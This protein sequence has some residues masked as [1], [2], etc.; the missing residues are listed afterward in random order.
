ML[1]V[2][3]AHEI[4]IQDSE[5]P[6]ERR[7]S[8][9][10]RTSI[11]GTWTSKLGFVLAT[12]GAA[13]GLGNIWMFPYM[14]GENGGGAFVIIFLICVALIGIPALLAEMVI[15]RR[16]K[17][18]PADSMQHVAIESGHSGNWKWAGW[19]AML[20]LV[21]VLSF[22]SVVSG[23]SLAYLMRA[24]GGVFNHASPATIQS[25]WTHFQADPW[26]MLLWHTVFMV[27]TMWIIARGVQAGIEKASVIMMP[28]LFV[29]LLLLVAYG[30]S[31]S[32]FDA[33]VS[34]L[35]HPDFS[36]VTAM[37][38]IAALGQALFSMAVGAGCMLI[39][40]AYVGKKTKLANAI[41]IISL[42]NVLVAILAG[43]AIF[44]IVFT[45]HLQAASGPAL[46]YM[47]LPIAF[48]HMVGG[49]LFE[50]LFFVLL[51]F[52]ALTSSV[53]Q[54]EPL[55]A[56]LMEKLKIKR[57]GAAFMVGFV[58]WVIG[59]GSLLSFNSWQHVK[60]FGHWTI[61]DLSTN[62]PIKIILP[63]GALSFVIFAG[64]VMKRT[65]IRDEASLTEGWVFNVWRFL[66]RYTVPIAIVVI[67]IASV[68]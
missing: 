34:F 12:T 37:T 43:L 42:L 60:L 67:M 62:I 45:H 48:S 64:W 58:A 40:G 29:I 55:V 46:M 68:I 36:K 3:L 13:V 24:I 6:I 15:G 21:L 23:W 44:P 17:C 8:V 10:E 52:A 66:I 4:T 28:L 19:F 14:A 26:E 57:N 18:N 53:S 63:I 11:H 35:F 31:T 30:F 56:L 54:A 32:G 39:Y 61:F 50:I 38:V 1:R 5:Q 41:W 59:I 2:D 22:Y 49:Q 65:V 51:F 47:T 9:T 27:L 7:N 33:A 25:V 16:G 20:A